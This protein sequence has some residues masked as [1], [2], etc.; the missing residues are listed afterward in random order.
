MS[1][2]KASRIPYMPGYNIISLS[3]TPSPYPREIRD[4]FYGRTSHSILFSLAHSLTIT[5]S[6]LPT[7]AF[8]HIH[9]LHTWLSSSFVASINFFIVYVGVSV[10]LEANFMR[11]FHQLDWLRQKS[12]DLAFILFSLAPC[13]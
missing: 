9:Y 8:I 2:S 4:E 6:V 11:A 13:A 3:Q 7:R 1:F 12:H 10:C 5:V